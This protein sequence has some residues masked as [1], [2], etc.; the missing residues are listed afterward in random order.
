M[1]SFLSCLSSL[2]VYRSDCKDSDLAPDDLRTIRTSL[3]GLIRYF[4]SKGG[5][6]EE[7]Q[8]IIGYI[9]T[10]SEEEQVSKIAFINN[11]NHTCFGFA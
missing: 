10:T 4:L 5:T 11:L 9:A 2:L 6:H 7:V 8:S 3:Y 1:K